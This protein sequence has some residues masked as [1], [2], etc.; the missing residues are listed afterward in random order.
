MTVN[1]LDLIGFLPP[2]LGSPY[3]SS[4]IEP[5]AD[6]IHAELVED[7]DEEVMLQHRVGSTV[8]LLYL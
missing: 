7:E 4:E 6:D 1:H 3:Y 5:P 8:M 2:D